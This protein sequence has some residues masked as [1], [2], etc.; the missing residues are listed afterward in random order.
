MSI[1]SF[2]FFSSAS[3]VVSEDFVILEGLLYSR[4]KMIYRASNGFV[5]DHGRFGTGNV[6]GEI[7]ALRKR[8][9]NNILDSMNVRES[10]ELL[11]RINSL[12]TSLMRA[13][14]ID[15][16][17]MDTLIERMLDN[18]RFAEQ[19]IYKRKWCPISKDL[20]ASSG[21]LVAKF[22]ILIGARN[23]IAHAGQGRYEKM[24]QNDCTAISNL[25][26]PAISS[27]MNVLER[28][29]GVLN[30]EI[31]TASSR[32]GPLLIRELNR[33]NVELCQLR[34]V[35]LRREMPLRS[36]KRKRESEEIKQTCSNAQYQNSIQI[37]HSATRAANNAAKHAKTKE[38]ELRNELKRRM[39]ISQNAPQ[40]KLVEA[41][42]K[43]STL[44]EQATSALVHFDRVQRGYE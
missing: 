33:M 5:Y 22:H 34:E 23:E 12:R 18:V 20:L 31:E 1:L 25:D 9:V 37:A 10:M 29:I 11:M 43:A 13:Y 26:T 44:R 28:D 38:I 32:L 27:R 41:A 16:D 39:G 6:N 30:E 8:Y 21:S 7:Y 42:M 14:T 15:N 35:Y 17:S 2:S 3:K 24:M 4:V 40:K 36:N 19:V